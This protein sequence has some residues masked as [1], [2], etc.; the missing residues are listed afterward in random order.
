MKKVVALVL[1]GVF[2]IG[3][4][5]GMDTPSAEAAGG[6]CY[7]T[8]GCNGTPLKCCVTAW[9]VFCKPTNVIQCPQIADC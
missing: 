4:A 8:C 6:N 1:A 9:G 7:Y 3:M 5:V 2:A